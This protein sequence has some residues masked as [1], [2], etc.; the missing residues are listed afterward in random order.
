MTW[1]LTGLSRQRAR[2][3]IFS[4]A[5]VGVPTAQTP[6]S[7]MPLAGGETESHQ[8]VMEFRDEVDA[9]VEQERRDWLEELV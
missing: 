6:A 8:I 3:G 9:Y 1:P 2:G 4:E 7:G 5:Y